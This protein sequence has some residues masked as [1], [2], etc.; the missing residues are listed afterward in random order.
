MVLEGVFAG[1]D[2][3][4]VQSACGWPLRVAPHVR[5]IEPPSEEEIALL[6]RLD[7]YHY[8]LTPGRY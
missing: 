2:P 6:R 8:Y 4:V 5:E 7:P 1:M 3:G